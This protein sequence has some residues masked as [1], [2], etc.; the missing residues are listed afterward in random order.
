MPILDN[1]P[2]RPTQRASRA[3]HAPRWTAQSV[4]LTINLSRPISADGGIIAHRFGEMG[5]F[6]EWTVSETVADAILFYLPFPLHR[7]PSIDVQFR[8]EG[9]LPFLPLSIPEEE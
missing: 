1:Q 2:P 6:N 5:R 4:F 8:D 7:L 3:P 9:R